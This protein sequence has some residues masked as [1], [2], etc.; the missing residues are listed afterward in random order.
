MCVYVVC[1]SSSSRWTASVGWFPIFFSVLL[2]L[3]Y[4]ARLNYFGGCL[5]KGH[6]DMSWQGSGTLQSWSP[7]RMNASGAQTFCQQIPAGCSNIPWSGAIVLGTR[8][9]RDC[10]CRVCTWANDASSRPDFRMGREKKLTSGCHWG[11]TPNQNGQEATALAI[12]CGHDHRRV[13]S[14]FAEVP[15]PSSPTTPHVSPVALSLLSP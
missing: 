1:S 14:P 13:I 10:T 7:R 9:C 6:V 3:I 12:V 15:R 2:N 5:Q 8:E 11:G 4:W